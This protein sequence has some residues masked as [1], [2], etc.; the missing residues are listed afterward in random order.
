[1]RV[2]VHFVVRLCMLPPQNYTQYFSTSTI[3]ILLNLCQ[4]GHVWPID[5]SSIRT[6][7]RTRYITGL[8]RKRGITH[9]ENIAVYRVRAAHSP[10]L[11]RAGCPCPALPRRCPIRRTRRGRLKHG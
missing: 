11:C 10:L 9:D 8:S 3:L 1:M 2:S 7:D 5:T 4:S 6:P